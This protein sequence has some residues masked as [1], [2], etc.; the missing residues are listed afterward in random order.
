MRE[1]R[2]IMLCFIFVAVGTCI[3]VA[4]SKDAKTI[5]DAI[6][7]GRSKKVNPFFSIAHVDERKNLEEEALMKY[8]KGRYIARNIETISKD[9]FGVNKKVVTSFEFMVQAKEVSHCPAVTAEDEDVVFFDEFYNNRN[10]WPLDAEA[11]TCQIKEGKLVLDLKGSADAGPSISLKNRPSANFEVTFCVKYSPNT[12]S[13][14][15]NL[16]GDNYVQRGSTANIFFGM[17]SAGFYVYANSAYQ[18]DARDQKFR[19][20]FD[21][22]SKIN[23]FEPNEFKIQKVNRRFRFFINDILT[24]ESEFIFSNLVGLTFFNCTSPGRQVEIDYV[25]VKALPVNSFTLDDLILATK[26]SGTAP[27]SMCK[28]GL[29]YYK[30]ALLGM[31]ETTSKDQKLQ[32]YEDKRSSRIRLIKYQIENGRYMLKFDLPLNVT[33]T[34]NGLFFFEIDYDNN[35]YKPI[36]YEI[37]N[38]RLTLASVNYDLSPFTFTEGLAA[39]VKSGIGSNQEGFLSQPIVLSRKTAT[40]IQQEQQTVSDNSNRDAAGLALLL[41]LG[42]AIFSGDGGNSSSNNQSSN[43]QRRIESYD[44][45][46]MPYYG[47]FTTRDVGYD[48]FGKKQG[49]W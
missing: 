48:Q 39:L 42:M 16:H 41:L 44:K 31:W 45:Y 23:P 3:S 19:N 49:Y 22:M 38:D 26:K 35:L 15:I 20:N 7:L 47:G 12:S 25:K 14:G 5:E 6:E 34:D 40:Q 10:N 11:Y 30:T 27:V 29:D 36:K 8:C 24:H 17:N 9:V 37:S 43:E 18:S 1:I 4:Q 46:G 28:K 21:V 33:Q 13:F 2:C 32:F